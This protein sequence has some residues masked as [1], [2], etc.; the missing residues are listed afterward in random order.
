MNEMPSPNISAP[1]NPSPGVSGVGGWL[2]LFCI[3]ITIISPVYSVI[4]LITGLT[5]SIDVLPIY[6]GYIIT[7]ITD[8]VL[9]IGL[10]GFSVYTGVRLWS[11]KP[12]A[13]RTAKILLVSLL[14]YNILSPLLIYLA[15]FTPS[16]NNEILSDYGKDF[17][18][19]IIFF[20]VWF[21]YLSSSKR[22]KNTYV[23]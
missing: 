21:A 18:R 10:I 6:P 22:V 4:L 5:Q 15:G 13:V 19:G 8:T 20:G 2:L 12:R 14:C 1:S 7:L 11:I 16:I 3:S 23:D 9:S 17:V